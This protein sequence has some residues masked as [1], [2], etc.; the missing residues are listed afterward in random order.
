MIQKRFLIEN[1]EEKEEKILTSIIYILEIINILQNG[2][3][4]EELI[5]FKT[6]RLPKK[7]F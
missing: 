1:E 4:T 3:R 2:V 7:L 6:T 5:L